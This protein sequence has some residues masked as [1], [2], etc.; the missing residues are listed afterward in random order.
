VSFDDGRFFS[1][2]DPTTGELLRMIRMGQIPRRLVDV[3]PDEEV[4]LRVQK[5]DQED[6]VAPQRER[7]QGGSFVGPGNRLGR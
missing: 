1:Y 6:Y 2:E 7:V 3:G 5:K 4:Q